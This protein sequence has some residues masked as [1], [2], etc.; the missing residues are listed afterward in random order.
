MANEPQSPGF[1]RRIA[2]LLYDGLLLLGVL[3]VAGLPLPLL[4]NLSHATVVIALT[5]I[6]LLL[7]AFLFLGWFWTHG[8]Q[9]LGMRAWRLRL[10]GQSGE[11]LNWQTASIRFA[12]ATLSLITFGLGF[13]WMF[14]DKEKRTWHDIASRSR[15]LLSPSSK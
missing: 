7:V 9:T 11:C 2:A 10:V 1:F 6:Y 3:F 15:V 4:E 14:F 5:R 8:G 13:F 12:V